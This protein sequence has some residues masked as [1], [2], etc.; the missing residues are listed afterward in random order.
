MYFVAI[1]IFACYKNH[2]GKTDITDRTKYYRARSGRC[3]LYE[4]P[5]DR[6]VNTVLSRGMMVC[7]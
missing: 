3:V 6:K 5:K 2:S 7:G 4:G 1:M